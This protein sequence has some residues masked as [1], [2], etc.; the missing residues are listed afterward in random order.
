MCTLPNLQGAVKLLQSQAEEVAH[1]RDALAAERSALAAERDALTERLELAAAEAAAA[2]EELRRQLDAA[3]QDAANKAAR[4]ADLELLLQVSI[5]LRI[6]NRSRVLGVT[7]HSLA[8]K[9]AW[10]GPRQVFLGITGLVPTQTSLQTCDMQEAQEAHASSE[11]MLQGGHQ[12]RD[13]CTQAD[14]QVSPGRESDIAKLQQQVWHAAVLCV[15]KHRSMAGPLAVQR[16]AVKLR[17]TAFA[18]GQHQD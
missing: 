6:C 7:V 8:N 3:W 5:L 18:G 10:W 4:A 16:S 9:V 12:R 2:Q 1:S 11:A 15:R 17:H 14:Q 13:G